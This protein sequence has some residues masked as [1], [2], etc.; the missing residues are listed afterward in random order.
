MTYKGAIWTPD[1]PDSPVVSPK[2]AGIPSERC[3]LAN[4][5]WGWGQAELLI[6]CTK[7]NTS[8]CRQRLAQITSPK[9]AGSM[10]C[11]TNFL[12]LSLLVFPLETPQA[13][14]YIV[15]GHGEMCLSARPHSNPD[16]HCQCQMHVKSMV[17]LAP[18]RSP[19]VCSPLLSPC[20]S[21]D[22]VAAVQS[23][24]SEPCLRQCRMQQDLEAWTSGGS[25]L[26]FGASCLWLRKEVTYVLVTEFSLQVCAGRQE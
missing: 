17:H 6:L 4:R 15:T 3:L 26:G 1:P 20:P 13:F 8:M 5:P 11:L 23:L 25:G 14:W 18:H 7:E 21:K 22:R 12:C 9:L 19:Q 16:D 24:L 10:I 2:P